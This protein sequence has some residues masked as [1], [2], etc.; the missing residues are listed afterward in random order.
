MKHPL[1]PIGARGRRTKAG[2]RVRIAGVPDL[3]G[4]K[5]PD[6]RVSE[7]VFRHI[8]GQCK[9]VSGLTNMDAQRFS[10]PYAVAQDEDC[11][12]SRLSLTSY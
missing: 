9:R 10:L 4:M 11:T 7:S 12:P 1:P 3:S 2:N 6:R 8:L 5:Q